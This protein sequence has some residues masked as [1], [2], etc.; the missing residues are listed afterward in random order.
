MKLLAVIFCL[1]VSVGALAQSDT[2]A[3]IKPLNAAIN[4][5]TLY[6]IDGEP[7]QNKLK[8][9]DPKDIF[10]VTILKNDSKDPSMGPSNK[11]VVVIVSKQS[12]IKMYQKKFSAFS[13]EYKAYFDNPQN[14]DTHF[15]YV[16]NGVMIVN[17]PSVVGNIK[18][19]YDIPVKKIKEVI[20]KDK[21]T[22]LENHNPI[23]I[24]TT[25]K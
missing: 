12:A 17:A 6:V 20:F 21:F 9:I 18:I 7:S 16:L 22:V 8:D 4:K 23:V 24:I 14:N 25:K 11:V 3:K 19:L 5:D 15:L 2:S 1:M 10:S 13:K